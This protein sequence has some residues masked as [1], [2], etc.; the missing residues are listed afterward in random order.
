MVMKILEIAGKITWR[1]APKWTWHLI[2]IFYLICW[3]VFFV[4]FGIQVG[5]SGASQLELYFADSV[6]GLAM[7][8][9]LLL[10]FLAMPL[11]WRA[12][13]RLVSVH[14]FGMLILTAFS[15]KIYANSL[16]VANPVSDAI[17]IHAVSYL[18]LLVPLGGFMIFLKFAINRELLSDTGE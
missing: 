11:T 7:I 1:L 6:Y 10:G 17:W 5:A 16:P 8:S 12:Y 3:T 4:V 15:L 9:A 18:E 14:S 13:W 2:G